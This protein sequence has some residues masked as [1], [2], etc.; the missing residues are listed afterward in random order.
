MRLRVLATDG[1]LVKLGGQNLLRQDSPQLMWASAIFSA[2]VRRP[3]LGS[4]YPGITEAQVRK[5][6]A[7]YFEAA[8]Q[9]RWR[10]AKE[11]R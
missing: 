2:G 11:R 5:S 1:R 10:G 7:E 6:F 4:I 3:Q 9:L 8:R